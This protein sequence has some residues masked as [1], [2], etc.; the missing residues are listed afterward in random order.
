MRGH[1]VP[2]E[3]QEAAWR[4]ACEFFEL[5]TAEKVRL[6]SGDLEYPYGYFPMAAEA[7]ARSTGRQTPADLKESYSVA[8]PYRAEAEAGGLR[9]GP[10]L[11]PSAPPGFRVAFAAYYA[12]MERLADRLMD[13]FAAA[14]R[15]PTGFFAGAID[16]HVSALR[17]LFYPAHPGTPK[18]GQ[19]RAGAHTDYGTLTILK[20]GGQSG[21]EIQAA[22]GA[23]NAVPEVP[24]GFIV[25]IGDLMARWTNDRWRSTVHRVA[26]PASGANGARQSLA[27]FHQP[28]WD[29]EI[30]ALPSCTSAEEPV[31][32]PP[33]KSGPWLLEKTRRAYGVD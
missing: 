26:L 24:G 2:P 16:R 11:W 1:G 13:L 5:P 29:A 23:W 19:L 10:A 17:A 6:R 3:V 12:E 4:A 8:P 20:T 9:T 32:H 25:N 7:L 28:N 15:L 14:L 31:R 30:V 21:L 33:V 22:D 27:F 18:V